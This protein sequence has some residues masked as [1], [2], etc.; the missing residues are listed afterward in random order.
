MPPPRCHLTINAPSPTTIEY[1]VSTASPPKNLRSYCLQYST[2]F[3]RIFLGFS[4]LCATLEKLS[5]A[6]LVY[7]F[8][9]EYVQ[10][11]PWSRFGALVAVIGFLIA[12]RWHCGEILFYPI[13]Y[14]IWEVYRCG[15]F[16]YHFKLYCPGA[17]ASSPI[18]SSH[19]PFSLS[20][21]PPPSI[22]HLL[23][24]T[25]TT[26]PMFRRIPPRTPHPRNPNHHPFL[27]LPPPS[28]HALHPHRPGPRR[29]H[30]RGLSRFRGPFLFVR[31]D[32][33]GGGSGG[34]FSCELEF[35]FDLLFGWE[36]GEE[37]TARGKM[38]IGNF[39]RRL[40]V[41][42]VGRL[43]ISG[44]FLQYLFNLFPFLLEAACPFLFFALNVLIIFL[45][46]SSIISRSCYCTPFNE[47]TSCTQKILPNRE[48]LEQV[49]RGARQCL[50]EPKE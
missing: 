5:V 43:M 42:L 6:P 4:I 25:N 10:R 49:W 35:R 12:R 2:I 27:L 46:L 50:Y 40:E 1:K 24:T 39:G 44:S 33:R 36:G 3:L 48:I 9:H 31:R 37:K 22:Y 14:I 29:L 26:L 8:R 7:G 17:T 32:G 20:Q 47:L 34:G 16:H 18:L 45:S 41:L 28:H 13:L 15:S 23:P 11:I 19:Q 21:I 30:P 38:K